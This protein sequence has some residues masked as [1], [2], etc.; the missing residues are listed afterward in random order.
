MSS[1]PTVPS[2][3]RRAT[4]FSK[5]TVAACWHCLGSAPPDVGSITPCDATQPTSKD[6]SA[7]QVLSLIAKES[8]A[9][10]STLLYSIDNIRHSFL[11]L[12]IAESF[13]PRACMLFSRPSSQ[14]MLKLSQRR[15]ARGAGMHILLRRHPSRSEHIRPL[16]ALAALARVVGRGFRLGLHAAVEIV[17]DVVPI[18]LGRAL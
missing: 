12:E 16:V 13:Q 2:S 9:S 14:R 5:N 6:S 4:K 3:C 1:I 8:S 17:P 18:A 10:R 15:S 11:N 7:V